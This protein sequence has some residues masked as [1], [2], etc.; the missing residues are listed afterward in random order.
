MAIPLIA[1]SQVTIAP[2]RQ[3]REF[4]EGDMQELIA[5]LQKP[6]GLLHPII[7]RE[8]S[9][10]FILV[11]GERRLRAA[12]EIEMLGGTLNFAGSR[13]EPGFIPYIPVG[14]LD[15]LSREEAELDENTKRAD[16][17]WVEQVEA[18]ARL[19]EIRKRIAAR[20]GIPIPS[21]TE[22]APSIYPDVVPEV[23]KQ[24]VSREVRLAPHLKDPEVR[25]AKTAKEAE[26]IILRREQTT[27]NTKLAEQVGKIAVAQ[28]HTILNE[29][30]K[31][32][33][34]GAA[35]NTY[36]VILSD[37]PYGMGADEFGDSGGLAAG[38]HGYSDSYEEWQD[39]MCAVLPELTRITTPDAA[40]YLFC[41]IDNFA[42]LRGMVE[43]AGWKPHRTPLI[44][45]KPNGSRAPWPDAGPQRKYEVI[46]FAKKGEMKTQKLRGDVLTYNPDA[47]LG[48]AA[49]KPVELFVDL[50]E[51]SS[52]PGMRVLD[53]CAGTGPLIEAGNKCGCLVTAVEKDS[54][55]F[56]IMVGRLKRLTAQKELAL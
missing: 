26:K 19:V 33:L 7:L 18:T 52:A 15:E 4:D 29:D 48:H 42:E 43:R 6:V 16:L 50:L 9:D 37:P 45:V 17:T 21:T 27:R 34:K 54:A 49:Q 38:A 22:L 35:A 32:W 5:S 12:Q 2:N 39:L 3:R 10:S 53:F 24:N 28:R 51:R 20:D 44:W 47:N 41:D 56:G 36:N 40:M 30:A 1:M 23:A 25:S 14:E 31:A 46:L 13:I 55:S 11:A 8:E